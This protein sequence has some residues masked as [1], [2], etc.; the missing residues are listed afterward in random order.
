MGSAAVEPGTQSEA[1]ICESVWKIFERGR[2][3]VRALSDISMRIRSGE[4]LAL[5][6]S[7]GSGK[8]T[9]L[10]LLGALDI[11]T[12]GEVYG[13]GF[14]YKNL[15]NEERNR[16]RRNNIGF[17]FQELRLISHLTAVQNVMLPRLFDGLEGAALTEQ[18]QSL[19]GRV[20]V[21]GRSDHFPY[22]LSYG[23][24]QRVAIARAII[25]APKIILADEPTA[26]LDV[27]NADGVV[28]ILQDLR[29]N[30]ATVVVATHDHRVM[31][32]ADRVVRIE[33][34]LLQ[35]I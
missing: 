10:N 11:P 35:Q 13:L 2:L 27:K 31:E 19:L 3:I 20:G 17:V 32:S 30:G 16:F 33:G 8:S 18:A 26:N 23:E 14:R 12:K 24:Q 5:V 1:L 34:G 9:L 6:G 25:T 22:E 7:S 29:A 21:S 4:V 15:S 28:G